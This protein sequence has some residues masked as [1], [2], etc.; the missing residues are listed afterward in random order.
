LQFKLIY[1]VIQ[2]DLPARQTDGTPNQAGGEV[3]RRPLRGK[4]V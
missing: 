2:I 1:S 3:F 4:I